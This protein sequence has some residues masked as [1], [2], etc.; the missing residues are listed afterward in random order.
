MLATSEPWPVSVM[1]KQPGISRLM[2]P[3]S[4]FSW[5]SSVPRW[6]T[7]EP[8][9]PHC[10]PA[11]IC[12][13]GS[14]M[15]S[16]S[17]PATLPPWSSE[18]PTDSGKARCTAPLSTRILSCPKTRWRCSVWVWP[19]ILCSSGRPARPRDCRRMSAHLPSSCSPRAATSTAGAPADR[20]GRN[21]RLPWLL[22]AAV[23]AAGGGVRCRW[24]GR[25]VQ[26][27]RFLLLVL[28]I[29]G[30]DSSGRGRGPACRCYGAP[31][32]PGPFV[33]FVLLRRDEVPAARGRCRSRASR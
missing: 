19:S 16:S 13:D 7:A 30:A 5:C 1:A 12:R 4:H 25:L 24:C 18:P 9:R 28:T 31:G 8:N 15:T 33:P 21:G 17:K 11:L 6:F 23:V 29:F 10:T 20:A 26:S 32:L 14:A 3:G 2:M 27:C 22:P